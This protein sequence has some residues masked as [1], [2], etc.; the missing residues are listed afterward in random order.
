VARISFR[1]PA[2]ISLVSFFTRFD[3]VT[4]FCAL[5]ALLRLLLEFDM[6]EGCFGDEMP[7]CDD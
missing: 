5:S 4:F 7:S 6:F 1:L 2:D 3:K